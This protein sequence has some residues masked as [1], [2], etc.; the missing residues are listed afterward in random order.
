[1]SAF[2]D[3]T[4]IV[5][6]QGDEPMIPPVIIRQ[7]AENLAQAACWYGDA[8]GTHSRAQKRRSIPTR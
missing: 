4:V 2:A 3:D 1:M 6:V 8:G 5:N 7:V